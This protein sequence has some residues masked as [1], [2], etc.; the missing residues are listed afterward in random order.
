MKRILMIFYVDNGNSKSFKN[1]NIDTI[2]LGADQVK[3]GYS[4][5]TRS[6]T[7]WKYFKM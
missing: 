3:W 1:E 2:V 6:K 7:W 5:R 4:R